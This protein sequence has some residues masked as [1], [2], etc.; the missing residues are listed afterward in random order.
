MSNYPP[1][2]SEPFNEQPFDITKMPGDVEPESAPTAQPRWETAA[3]QAPRV[4]WKTSAFDYVRLIT[5][6][7]VWLVC[8]LIIGLLCG[9]LVY[10]QL[11]PEFTATA[12]VLVSKRTAVPTRQEGEAHTWGDR[13]EHIALIMSPLIVTR[14]IE[15]HDLDKLPTLAASNDPVEDI[16]DDLKVTRSAGLDQSVLNVLDVTFKSKSRDD[17]KKVVNA[18]IDAY[19]KFLK[20]QHTKN[21]N[22]LI[23][24][25]DKTSAK[26]QG[27]IDKVE[28]EYDQFRDSAPV[29]LRTSE[30]GVNGE[31]ISVPANIHQNTLDTLQQK[32]D[33]LLGQRNEV[34]SQIQAIESALLAGQPREELAA[35]IQLFSAPATASSGAAQS[36]LAVNNPNSV[37]AS[38]DAQLLPL[39]LRERQL[40][41]EFGP[42]WPEVVVVRSQMATLYQYY[43][44][45]GLPIPGQAGNAART[46][47]LTQ[48]RTA[49]G[50]DLI[51]LYLL[52]LRQKL[53]SIA[54]QE[55]RIEVETKSVAKKAR[56]LN[57]YLDQDRKFNDR[58]D[59]L[60]GLWNLMETQ[61]SKLD[62]E[63]ETPGYNLQQIAPARD[64][65]SLKRIA[66]L[67]GA[68]V[69]AV[70]GLLGAIIFWVEWRDTTL[71]SVE[72]IRNG[73][74]LPI[75]GTVPDFETRVRG[76]TGPLQPA[77]CYYHTPGSPEA[78]AYRSVRTA[79]N[80]CVSSA[81]KL[82]QVTSPEP[83]DGKSTLISNLAIAIA[84]S[85]RRVLLIDADLRKPTLHRLFGLRQGIGVTDVVNG[86]IDLLTATQPTVVDG[87]CVLTSGDIPNSPAE[88]LA[89]QQFSRLLSTAEREFDF[90]LI[91]TPPLLAVSDPC[92]VSPRTHGMILV[93]RL[94]KN[95]RA[96]ARRA[97]QLIETNHV[98]VIGIVANGSEEAPDGYEYRQSYGDYLS[99]SKS[100]TIQK[101]STEHQTPVE[102]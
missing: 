17:A 78:E 76:V 91:D 27:D 83:G 96:S 65:L 33:L 47:P 1:P 80:V 40:I 86:E 39:L 101:K 10:Q 69:I 42:D 55:M 102:V 28:N 68:G 74:A 18:V 51:D 20:S 77:L 81:Q 29:Y 88:L 21:T 26:I 4:E 37:Q 90:V 23:Q 2:G 73:L 53:S 31:R 7:R 71:K 36:P 14:A 25:V 8:G 35:T 49:S 84:Q 64:Q 79:F 30:R 45:R 59:R 63:K 41:Y 44:Q 15:L 82:I 85:G 5:K 92:I 19:D 22:E 95:S 60:N 3:P 6:Y 89:S 48:L 56:T 9:H 11:G 70:C 97:A 87:L 98:N 100:Q 13:A 34:E 38:L 62:I 94:Q 52:S 54:D 72:E 32:R 75:L 16:I 99:S 46:N 66:K 43:Q 24:L 50:K 93:L 57:A 58:I 61:A 67:Y 12:K